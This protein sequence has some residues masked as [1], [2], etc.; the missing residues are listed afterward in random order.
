MIVSTA[1]MCCYE[2]VG[3]ATLKRK[4]VY[5]QKL[6]LH[7]IEV[8]TESL[9]ALLCSFTNHSTPCAVVKLKETSACCI[10]LTDEVLI[11]GC[12][13]GNQIIE[14]RI[15]TACAEVVLWN[16][17]LLEQLRRSWYG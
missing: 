4:V 11:C 8:R 3:R 10:E 9:I 16:G 1:D 15:E 13:V 12:D 17:E 2:E 5:F 7:L 14:V 6:I